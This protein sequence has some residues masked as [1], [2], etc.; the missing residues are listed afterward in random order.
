ME[1]I[2]PQTS[3]VQEAMFT[4]GRNWV[5]SHPVKPRM[6]HR[7][8]ALKLYHWGCSPGV[9]LS[10]SASLSPAPFLHKTKSQC[11]FQ[12]KNSM[13]EITWK[14]HCF[15]FILS[16]FL[17]VVEL[18]HIELFVLKQHKILCAE[19][20]DFFVV[21]FRSGTYLLVSSAARRGSHRFVSAC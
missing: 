16:C 1:V 20:C 17:F 4:S 18:S 12:T 11:P 14:C 5:R 6:F 15:A 2:F 13:T 7:L 9:T 21:S 8:T 10:K 3:C 19:R